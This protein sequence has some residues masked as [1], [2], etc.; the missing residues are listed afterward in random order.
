MPAVR[1][2]APDSLASALLGAARVCAGVRAGRPLRDGLD[3]ERRVGRPDERATNDPIAAIHDLAARTLR[4]RARAD[5]LLAHVGQRTPDPPL[6]RELLVVAIA[7]LVDALPV[8]D[9]DDA[10]FDARAA[11]LAY[12]PF[13]L[14][15]Q[16]V[17]AASS[18]PEL[19]RGKGFV[20]AVLRTLLRRMD[21]EPGTLA[22]VLDADATRYELPDWWVARLKA[23]YPDAWRAVAASGLVAPPLTLRVN[24]SR[25]TRDAQ[26]A[27]LAE[28]GFAGRALGDDAIRLDRPVPVTRIPG[29]ADGLVSV[30]DEAAQRAAP[31][32]DAADGMRVLDACAAPGGKTGHLLERSDVDCVALD[33][34]AA[35]LG[36]VRDNLD[37]LGLVATL[38]AGDA[39]RP[40][41]WW[42]GRRFDRILADV[43]CTAS[44][45][46]RRHPDIRWLR[47]ERDIATLSRTAQQITD[48]LWPLLDPGGKLLL[49]TCSVFPEESARHAARF[50]ATHA[51]ARTLP[52]PGQLLPTGDGRTTGTVDQDHDGL[53]FA[54]FEKMR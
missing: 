40:D 34:D 36:R 20:N 30:Q 49:V 48:A 21:Q 5:A 6:L 24:Q 38:V 9:A 2:L 39:A 43:P 15:D 47:R 51:D 16:A 25:T 44:G 1:G 29:F 32:L 54:L 22:A 46:L 26:L 53:F 11:R 31:L 27:R 7:L 17:H 33:V 45:I 41:S 18:Q 13:T 10:T 35:R 50:A 14:V 19:A 12:A 28:A 37:R 23:A 8:D 52:A 4:R 3:A 42:D